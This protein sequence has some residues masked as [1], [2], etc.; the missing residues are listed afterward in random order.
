MTASE[1]TCPDCGKPIPADAPEGDLCPRCLLREG[2]DSTTPTRAGR[3]T[4]VP[5]EPEELSSRFPN[6]E[7]MELIGR[8]GMGAVYKA[9]QLKLD[10]IV[11]LKILTPE[12]ARAVGFSE[13]F[14]REARTLARLSHPHIVSIHDFGEEDGTFYFLMEFVDGANLREVLSSG[15][16]TPAEALGIIPQICDA[17]QFA[18]EEGVVH[19]D[20]K[21]ENILL[22]RRGNVKIADFGLAKLVQQAADPDTL[23]VPGQVMGTPSYMAP[24]QIERP[25]EVDHRADI[26]SLG[27]VFYEMLTG[28]LPLGRFP[29]PSSRV[30]VDVRLDDVVLRALEKE[31]QRRYQRAED[32]KTDLSSLHVDPGVSPAAGEG[33]P[34]VTPTSIPG[35][36]TPTPSPI[37]G[38]T[39]PSAVITRTVEIRRPRALTLTALWS[40]VMAGLY[41]SLMDGGSVWPL[42]GLGLGAR[43]IQWILAAWQ[44]AVGIGILRLWS[45]ARPQGIALAA[46]G[47]LMFPSG[48]VLSIPALAYLLRHDV[49]RL[50]ELGEGPAALTEED[51]R[52]V[53][54]VLRGR[55]RGKTREV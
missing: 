48:T 15:S 54:R 50:F 45:W 41:V 24:E 11:A 10:R 47:C 27:V 31:P 42:F 7:V 18:H 9:R 22:D 21:P 49:A 52:Q 25:S 40:F 23:T 32:V 30:Q 44:I 35:L 19:R 55:R 33:A 36:R 37:P 8:G 39:A 1:R 43:L 4:F 14:A 51:A 28:E 20:I 12:A 2:L 26:F 3:G 6:L 29:V 5:P 13:R 34:R 53:E 38:S 46:L 16:L 17:L